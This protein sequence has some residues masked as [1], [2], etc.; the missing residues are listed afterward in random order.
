MVVNEDGK[1][2]VFNEVHPLNE[3]L[4][5]VIIPVLFKFTEVN[6]VILRNVVS[7]F[8]NSVF[9]KSTVCNGHPA[10]ILHP[11]DVNNWVILVPDKFKF[12]IPQLLNARAPMVVNVDGKVTVCNEVHPKNT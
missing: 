6:V 11:L 10:N 3:S 8:V 5:N 1:V 9:D 12:C 7:M 4:L 2:I